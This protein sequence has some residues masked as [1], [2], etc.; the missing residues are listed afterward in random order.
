[1][2]FE[3]DGIWHFKDIHGQLDSKIKKDQTLEK[4][5]IENDWR[6]IRIKDEIY[7]TNKTYYLDLIENYV[8]KS[9]EQIIKIY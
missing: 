1:V 2:I 5:V 8:Y 9:K 7:N 6:L 4:W 3:Y